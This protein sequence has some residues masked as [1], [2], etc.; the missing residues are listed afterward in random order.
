MEINSKRATLT[1]TTDFFFVVVLFKTFYIEV[2]ETSLRIVQ[3]Y[4]RNAFWLPSW[5]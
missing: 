2:I 3:L 4:A 1:H 5:L